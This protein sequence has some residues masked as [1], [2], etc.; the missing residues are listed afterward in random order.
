MVD[1]NYVEKTYMKP[2]FC[3]ALTEFAI[4][5]KESVPT[6]KIRIVKMIKEED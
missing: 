6:N 1:D 2:D 3:E 4:W 5:L